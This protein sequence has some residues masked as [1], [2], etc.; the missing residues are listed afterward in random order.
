MILI[1]SSIMAL[2]VVKINTEDLD[3]KISTSGTPDTPGSPDTSETPNTHQSTQSDEGRPLEWYYDN[4]TPEDRKKI[5]QAMDYCIPRQHIIEEI[6]KGFAVP[7][8]TDIGWNMV[9]YDPTIQPREYNTATALALLT[10]VFGK[11]YNP[12]DDP[13][14]TITNDP[15]FKMTLV[16]PTT[17]VARTQWAALICF[18]FNNVGIDATL[19]W[20]DWNVIMPRLFLDPPGVGL[21]YAHGGYDAYFIGFGANPDPDYSS[22]YFYPDEFAPAGDNA[23][24]I[25]ND[26]VVEIINRSITEHELDNRLTAL[27]EYQAWFYE[28][29][30]KSIIR[31]KYDLFGCDIDLVGLDTYRYGRHSW[32]SNITIPGQDT[33]TFTSPGDLVDFNPLMSVSWWDGLWQSNCFLSLAMRRGAYNLTHAVP[34]LADSW[35]RSVDGLEWTVDLKPGILW[36][37]GTP[38]TVDDVKFSYDSCFYPANPNLGFMTDRF[39]VDATDKIEIIDSDTIKFT[40]KAFYPFMETQVFS[41]PIVQKAQMSAISYADWKT[42]GTNTGSEKIIGNGPYKF[43]SYSVTTGVKLVPNDYYNEAHFQDLAAVGGPIWQPNASFDIVREVVVKEAT[44]AVV[45]LAA[46]VYDCVDP[47]TGLLALYDPTTGGLKGKE[48]T[49]KVITVLKYGWQEL[50][51][52]HYDPRWGLNPH[53]P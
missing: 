1:T 40:L 12:Y 22:T 23:Q 8:A 10:D 53:D 3:E 5:R 18:A 19:K 13:S 48:A 33:F 14:A 38:V 39:G 41:L 51:Y 4:L 26:E 32:I 42:D 28:N 25:E 34:C 11:E 24:W 6:M 20:W 49:T 31:Q 43:D 9:G 37:D 47:Q 45:G 36:D 16:T 50:A 21:D 15:Y 27:K 7:L 17:N 35:S 46:G 29:V 30:P 2:D 44:T 52:N